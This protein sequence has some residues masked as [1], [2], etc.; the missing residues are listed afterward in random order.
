MHQR[1]FSLARSMPACH[2]KPKDKK[3]F[4]GAIGEELVRRHGKRKYY[5]PSE[6]RRAAESRGYPVDVHCWAYC[7]YST[8]ADFEALHHAAGEVCD[9]AVMK[10]EVLAELA[11]AGSFSWLDINLSW[12]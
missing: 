11:T 6:I 9:Y 7:I 4:I 3:A 2:L 8:S 5:K 10:A 1:A 12:L